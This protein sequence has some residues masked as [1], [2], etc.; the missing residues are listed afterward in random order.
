M[1]PL[2][3]NRYRHPSG[4]CQGTLFAFQDW[5]STCLIWPLFL[6]KN[7]VAQTGSTV[8][9]TVAALQWGYDKHCPFNYFTPS[10]NLRGRSSLPLSH[11]AFEVK[12]HIFAHVLTHVITDFEGQ[13]CCLCGTVTSY[14]TT[15]VCLSHVYLLCVLFHVD[16][17][18]CCRFISCRKCE[19]M[20]WFILL[21]CTFISLCRLCA[22]IHLVSLFT[23][24][25]LSMCSLWH[26]QQWRRIYHHSSKVVADLA[27]CLR[28]HTN[29]SLPLNYHGRRHQANQALLINCL[30]W[31][32]Q[33]IHFATFELSWLR[34]SR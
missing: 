27:W 29:Q 21:T 31:G 12:G 20:F 1:S 6:A 8:C 13:F 18:W 34:A 23:H 26:Y 7:V 33:A 30:D 9:S 25:A 15:C 3:Q 5:E 4:L 32:C 28:H 11:V 14:W 2:A 10:A 16:S 19:K 17:L 24:W 22:V